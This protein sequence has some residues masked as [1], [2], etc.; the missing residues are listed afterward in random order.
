MG[1]INSGTDT[2]DTKCPN[3]TGKMNTSIK[4]EMFEKF[5]IEN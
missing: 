4:S 1:I 3:N 2:Y 5:N